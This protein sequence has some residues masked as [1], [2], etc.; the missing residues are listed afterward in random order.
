[1]IENVYWMWDDAV[2]L[3]FCDSQLAAINWEEAGPGLVS[4][5]NTLNTE[6]RRTDIIWQPPLSVLGCVALAHIHSANNQAGWDYD[7][8][9]IEAVQIG[10]YKAEDKGYYNWHL[11]CTPPQDGLQ[12][13]LSCVMFL[14]DASEFE[15]GLLQFKVLEDKPIEAKRGRIIV[16]PSFVEHQVTPVT[17]GTRY[18]AVTWAFG[19][20]F[21]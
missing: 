8:S 14:N 9:N 11:D 21:K 3:E 17:A 2:P 18:T 12:R 10:R 4:T 20:T 16:F 19:P 6:R 13:K 5:E 1:M 15:G 7:F